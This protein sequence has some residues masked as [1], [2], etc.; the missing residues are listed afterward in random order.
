MAR[1]RHGQ[2]S[3]L[4]REDR[5]GRE[6][7]YAKVRV[8]GRQVKR[9]LGRKRL[10]GSR[11]GLTKQAEGALNKLVLALEA[12]PPRLV[13]E[14][15]GLGEVG[16]AYLAY[17]AT[18]GRRRSTL[19]EYESFL[20][21]HLVAFFGDVAI[22]KIDREHVEAFAARKLGRAGHR[23]RSGTISGFCIR[24]SSSRR[25]AAGRLVTR[26]AGEQHAR[27]YRSAP[28]DAEAKASGY[29]EATPRRLKRKL[30]RSR[31]A[32]RRTWPGA[33]NPI[34]TCA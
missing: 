17:L 7:W 15:H 8:D 32:S 20:R 24:S 12:E 6:T 21:V 4:V 11:E 14:K 22:E 27:R 9:A 18:R 31:S 3:L 19:M 10:A 28:W 34:A 16:E 23:S 1:R 29:L 30:S 33:V 26:V 25:S 13:V 2:G 5:R